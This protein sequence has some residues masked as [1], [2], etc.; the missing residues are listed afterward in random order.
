[1]KCAFC[2]LE[3]ATERYGLCRK[4]HWHDKWADWHRDLPIRE[5]DEPSPITAPSGHLNGN[6]GT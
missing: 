3:S 1:M 5:K 4:C 2:N 6:P